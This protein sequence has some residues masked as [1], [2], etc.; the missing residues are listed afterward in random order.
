MED[1]LGS[2]GTLSSDGIIGCLIP[3]LETAGKWAGAASDLIALV[4]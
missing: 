1:F 2:W 4:L 3:L